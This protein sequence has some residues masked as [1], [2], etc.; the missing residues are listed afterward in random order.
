[1][2]ELA[3]VRGADRVARTLHAAADDLRTMSDAAR[4]YGDLVAATGRGFA[5]VR[6]GR[7]RASITARA[8]AVTAAAPYA[9]AVEYGTRRGTRPHRYMGRAVDATEADR[10]RIYTRSAD[11]IGD[12][13]KGV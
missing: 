11:R 2:T 1:M 10:D 3:R 13:V 5:P 9:A 8:A 6:T 12:T 7:L 4:E